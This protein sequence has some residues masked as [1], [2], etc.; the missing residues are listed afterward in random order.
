MNQHEEDDKSH[1]SLT[2]KEMVKLKSTISS[3][4]ATI[5][6]LEYTIFMLKNYLCTFSRDKSI[7]FKLPCY[8]LHKELGITFFSE[9]FHTSPGGY[10][11]CIEVDHNDYGASMGTHVSISLNILDGQYDYKLPW[12][13]YFLPF[14]PVCRWPPPQREVV[15][16][17]YT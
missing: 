9:P 8:S 6:S 7:T 13:C 2:L 3:Q 10:K 17:C 15:I 12:P 11:M 4:M 14:K 5:S 1:L 16:G